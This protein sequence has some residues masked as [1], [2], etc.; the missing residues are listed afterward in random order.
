MHRERQHAVSK[1]LG[2]RKISLRVSEIAARGLEMKRDRVMDAALDL[3]LQQ[4]GSDRIATFAADYEQ[5]ITRL[6]SLWL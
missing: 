5:V 4:R 1:F 2:V 3:I 6:A